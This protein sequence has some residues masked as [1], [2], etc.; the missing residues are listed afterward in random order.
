[1][2]TTRSQH[3]HCWDNHHHHD[4]HP[5]PPNPPS[6]IE[7][8][9]NASCSSNLHPIE[10]WGPNCDKWLLSPA[11]PSEFSGTGK[12]KMCGRRRC[13]AASFHVVHFI[14]TLDVLLCNHFIDKLMHSPHSEQWTVETH[15]S[16]PLGFALDCC[17][18]T[19]TPHVDEW[20][21]NHKSRH[22]NRGE[23]QLIKVNSP[24]P[25][26]LWVYVRDR[27][28]KEPS[29]VAQPSTLRRSFFLRVERGPF[30]KLNQW[31]WMTDGMT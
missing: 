21:R 11:N 19:P 16:S 2:I 3:P 12:N 4:S 7:Y 1:M 13:S 14:I 22:R 28:G 18:H 31:L 6:M 24:T 26:P 15:T 10:K 23:T 29:F 20:W 27:D 8:E 9:S 30:V 5:P 17:P 25:P